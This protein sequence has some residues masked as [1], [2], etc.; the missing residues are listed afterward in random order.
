L[1]IDNHNNPKTT[2]QFLG[3][4]RQHLPFV[5]QK[6]QT[7]RLVISGRHLL[8]NSLFALPQCPEVNGERSQKTALAVLPLFLPFFYLT[9]S[10][11]RT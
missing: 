8:G 11:S 3:E 4:V 6:I 2:I 10:Y 1:Q 5:I 9:V 7:A